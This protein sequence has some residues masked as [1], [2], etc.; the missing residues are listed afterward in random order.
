MALIEIDH[1]SKTYKS[2]NGG[3][4]ANDDVTLHIDEGKVFGLFG[5]NGAGKTTIVNQLL[6][7]LQPDS[8][9]IVV[10]GED[11]VRHRERGRYLC[12]V[13]PQG[14]VPLGEL[15]PRAV[16][17]IMA[18]LRGASDEEVARKTDE[19]FERL[20]IAEWADQP[21]NKLSGGIL[22]LTGFCMAAIRPG[23]AV[24]LDE[25]TND[26]DPVRRRLLWGAIRD[27]TRDGTSVLLVTHSISEAEGA[28]DEMAILDEG[29]VLVQGNA[30]KIKAETVGDRMK[31]EAITTA[32]RSVFGDPVWADQLEILEGQLMVSFPSNRAADALGWA[33]QLQEANVMGDYSLR[34]M[35]LEDTYIQLVGSK[36]NFEKEEV[37]THAN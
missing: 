24:V 21:G 20:D 11:I 14:S 12:S 1:V 32:P 25:P 7:L 34:E 27:L 3:V 15:T 8:G 36:K 9:S 23:R 28:V 17:R 2:R 22:R 35:S 13:Q 37:A 26:V 16:T 10:A 4:L 5:H 29:R 18:K 19:L 31:L 33:S 30:A 6:G